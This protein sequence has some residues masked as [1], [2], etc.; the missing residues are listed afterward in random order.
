MK[1]DANKKYEIYNSMFLN[2][3][4]QDSKNIGHLLPLLSEFAKKRLEKRINPVAILNDFIANHYDTIGEDT[5]AFMFKVIQYV[6]RQ[7][8]LFDSIE[9]SASPKQLEDGSFLKIEDILTQTTTDENFNKLLDKLNTFKVRV[10]LTAHPTQFYTPAVL[11]IISKLR[12]QVAKNDIEK[13]DDLLHQL[14]LTSLI[15][16]KS[17]TPFDEAM[18]ILHICRYYYYDA[19]GDLY[20]DLS[21]NIPGFNNPELVSLG[22]WPCGDRDGNPYVT[23]QT[24]KDVCDALRMT[25]MKC[26][27]H[28]IK[29]LLSKMTFKEVDEHLFFLK[30]ELYK[31]MFNSEYLVSYS[32]I[33]NVLN[34][35]EVLIIEKYQ[36]LYLDKLRKIQYKIKVFKNHFASLDIRQNHDVHEQTITFILKDTGIIKKSL[37]E[38]TETN[39]IKL[40]TE[41]QI[42]IGNYSD[43]PPIIQDTIKNI[44]QLDKL[45]TKNGELGCHRYIISNSE[46]IFSVLFVFGLMRWIHKGNML[47]FDIVPLFETMNG[48][49]NSESI[50]TQLFEN[51][52]YNKHLKSRENKQIIMLGFSDGTKDGGYLKANWSIYKSKEVLTAVCHNYGVNAVFFDG[53]GGPPARGG[54]KTHRFYAAQGSTIANNELQ[55]T[56]QG[57]TITSTYG[58]KDRFRF[59]AEQLVT[60]GLHNILHGSESVISLD[61]RVLIEQLSELSFTKYEKL[62]NHKKF[63][64]Y[65]E[66]MTTLKYYSLARI[67]SRPSKRN[68]DAKLKLSDLRAIA[69]VGSWSQLKQNIPGYFGIGTAISQIKSEGNIDKVK[70]LYKNVPFFKTLIDNSMMSLTKCYFELTSYIK[71]VEEFGDFWQYLYDEYLLSKQMILEITQLD[72]LMQHEEKSKMSI[73]TREQIV[74]PLLIIQNYAIQK[75]LTETDQNLI[76]AYKKLIVRSLYG[77][78]NASRNSA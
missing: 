56:I 3:S 25:L 40:L 21:T 4:Y 43:A 54:G 42:E 27:Y 71:D 20:Y 17:P 39:L 74:L 35:V 70:N 13:I 57:Q 11:S 14:G 78:I 62:K 7:I 24:T 69:Y 55:L 32:E 18:N 10:V 61:D 2:L 34:K 23:Y 38:L 30:E 22:F 51:E 59:N 52:H 33:L 36:S 50:M 48:M 8:V 65:I 47:N 58:T 49:S 16:S 6:E 31:A 46:D 72:F 28:D 66:K 77:N 9:D 68:S 12:E 67:G 15:N 64:P 76:A 29:R 26:Y 19:L 45:Q 5:L 73:Q 44:E 75:L 1:T 63:L 53:R 60:S 41:D 37:D